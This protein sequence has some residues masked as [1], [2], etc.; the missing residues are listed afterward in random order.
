MIRRDLSR[1]HRWETMFTNRVRPNGARRAVPAPVGLESKGGSVFS[2]KRPACLLPGSV[3][4][5]RR[6]VRDGN[7]NVKQIGD[8]SHQSLGIHTVRLPRRIVR[9]V[10]RRFVTWYRAVGIL[11]QQLSLSLYGMDPTIRTMGRPVILSLGA[12]P[13]ICPGRCGTSHRREDIATQCNL[14]Y[15]H[16]PTRIQRKR[17]Q[18]AR[19]NCSQ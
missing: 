18:S 15:I 5:A 9:I 12:I 1:L 11:W 4:T 2:P 6:L 3:R 7:F 8:R 14:R 13:A 19:T 10:A 16:V 17:S